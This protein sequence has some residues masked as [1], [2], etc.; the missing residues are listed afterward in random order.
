MTLAESFP[1]RA[2]AGK[3]QIRLTVPACYQVRPVSLNR[4][5]LG[6]ECVCTSHYNL[7][8]RRRTTVR[9]PAGTVSAIRWP[10]VDAEPFP[11][12]SPLYETQASAI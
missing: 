10:T 1:A 5:A 7:C 9:F 6:R 4:S 3:R 2:L 11:T 8:S 12:P